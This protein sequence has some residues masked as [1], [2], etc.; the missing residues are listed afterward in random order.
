MVDVAAGVGSSEGTVQTV[1]G[2]SAATA[3]VRRRSKR[4]I[5][6]SSASNVAFRSWSGLAT[7]VAK[8]SFEQQRLFGD[9]GRPTAASLFRPLRTKLP[10]DKAIP[11]V[12]K[13][14][15]ISRRSGWT[16]EGLKLLSDVGHD[17]R[18]L[19]NSPARLLA[20]ASH[21][22][23]Y[24]VSGECVAESAWNQRWDRRVPSREGR[25]DGLPQTQWIKREDARQHLNVVVV[26]HAA[27]G[28]TQGHHRMKLLCHDRLRLIRAQV[29]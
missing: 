12:M 10:S 9:R 24:G 15:C 28:S 5:G 20:N 2:S 29:R 16:K 22:L 4:T 26:L 3:S 13:S 21:C 14:T 17:D 7:K 11:E 6:Q 19:G 27:V 23:C 8:V 1:D 18:R 25:R